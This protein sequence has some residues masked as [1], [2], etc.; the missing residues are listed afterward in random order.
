MEPTPQIIRDAKNRN[1]HDAPASNARTEVIDWRRALRERRGRILGDVANIVMALRL[2]PELRGS[3]RFN[4]FAN[5]AEAA[6]NLPWRVVREDCAW[7][8]VDD[9]RLRIWLEQRDVS[10]SSP[11]VVSDAVQAVAHDTPFHPVR[12]YLRRLTWDGVPRL[13]G[14]LQNY[15]GATGPRQYLQAVGRC[16]LIS[17]VARVMRPGCQVDHVL[18]LEGPQGIGKTSAI[19]VLGGEWATDCV[20]GMEGVDAAIQLS[21]KWLVELSELASM[22]RSEVEVVKAFVSRTVDRYRPPY[23]RRA[24]DVPRQCVFIGTTNCSQ[25]LRD[26]TGNR[27][28]WPVRCEKVDVEAIEQDRNHLWAEAFARYNGGDVWHLDPATAQ[29]AAEEQQ[30]RIFV[31]EI[32]DRIARYLERIQADEVSAGE[33]Y[34]FAL[35]LDPDASDYAERASRLSVQVAAAVRAAG[36]VYVGRVGRGDTRRTI[37]RR[38][39]TQ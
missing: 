9:I 7:T 34:C 26:A 6:R 10:P 30:K 22:R 15:L 13:D 39:D 20:H 18:V 4:V 1:Q 35:G 11:N 12:E 32:D 37:Y 28:F 8:D 25:Y 16:L 14:W 17:A 2:A 24:V 38:G 5:R 31:S 36:W 19:R 27:R 33:L 23:G 29:V 3:L 21:G